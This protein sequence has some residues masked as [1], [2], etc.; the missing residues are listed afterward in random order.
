MDNK[1]QSQKR[2]FRKEHL[3]TMSNLLQ[4]IRASLIQ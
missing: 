1:A 2:V 4:A 3:Q